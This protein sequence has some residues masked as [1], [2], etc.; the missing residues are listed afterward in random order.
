[1]TTR[2]ARTAAPVQAGQIHTALK[3]F[4]L[5]YLRV[6]QAEVEDRHVLPDAEFTR[7]IDCLMELTPNLVSAA[8]AVGR[9]VAEVQA[10]GTS[11]RGSGL[12]ELRPHERMRIVKGLLEQAFEQSR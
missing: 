10:W 12:A 5:Q 4:R 6:L 7:I 8:R 9:D 2:N 1:M 3:H 11:G